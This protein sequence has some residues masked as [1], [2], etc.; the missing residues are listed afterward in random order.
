MPKVT[1]SNRVAAKPDMIWQAIGSFGGIADW[2]PMVERA[3]TTGKGEGSVRTLHLVGGGKLVEKLEQSNAGERRYSYTIVEGPL[4]VQGYS[5]EVHVVDNGDGTSTVEWS[6]SFETLA[7][8]PKDVIKSVE[9]IYRTG[10]DNLQK[11]YGI[12]R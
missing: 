11:L 9:D 8:D 5:S 7:A 6:G 4:P 10:L 12:G 3:E 2:H 1:V